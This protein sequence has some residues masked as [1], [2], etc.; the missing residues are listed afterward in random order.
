MA[1][2][3]DLIWE[4]SNRVPHGAPTGT[5][6]QFHQRVDLP[7]ATHQ[8]SLTA[9]INH[10]GRRVE[11]LL[12]DGVRV[13]RTMLLELTCPEIECPHAR[14][15]RLQWDRY[16]RRPPPP[17]P[18]EP[19][20]V[21]RLIEEHSLVVDRQQYTARPARFSCYMACP[22]GAHDSM[23]IQKTGYDLFEQGTCV[24][25]GVVDVYGVMRP[26]LPTLQAADAFLRT[27]HLV[28]HAV[29]GALRRPQAPT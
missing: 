26:R 14:A 28:A 5:R 23:V 4:L 2:L 10:K 6:W 20:R 3:V 19:P 27:G 17:R 9:R 25:G 21:F 16:H 24:A 8:V 7:G 29:L 13:E 12:C 15:A 22:N 11:Q 1:I 18:P